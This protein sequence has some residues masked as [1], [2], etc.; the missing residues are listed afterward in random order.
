MNAVFVGVDAGGSRTTVK[1]VVDGSDAVRQYEVGETLSG[2]MEPQRYEGRLR[3][4]LAPLEKAYEQL[5]VV[6]L[7]TYLFIGA[8]AYTPRVRSVI[9]RALH[10]AVPLVAGPQ[11]RVAGA[12]N[13]VVTLLFGLR[14]DGVVIAGTGSNV[15]IKSA[16]G[17]LLQIGG[18]EWVACDTGAGFWIGLRAIRQAYRDFEDGDDS[19]LLQRFRE[20]YG[21]VK[22]DHPALVAT[23]RRLAIAGPDMKKHIARFCVDVCRA[24]ERGDL[25]AQSIVRAEAEELADRVA[26][27]LRRAFDARQ[28]SSGVSIVQ[29][30][31]VVVGNDFYRAT[32]ERRVE[33]DLRSDTRPDVRWHPVSTGTDAAVS[34]ARTLRASADELLDVAEL[35]RPVVVPLRD[36]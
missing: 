27:G 11:V 7:P 5:G 31:S 1:V 13:D 16:T 3:A 24:A 17:S 29:C 33:N 30:G 6:G 36:G 32:F 15:L 12:A 25:S 18:Q 9:R 4:I 10:R 35:H 26:A 14:A 19:V 8:A 2:S 21:V 23:A 28:L 22:D 34:L 20:A